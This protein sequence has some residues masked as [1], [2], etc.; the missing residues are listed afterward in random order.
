MHT[1]YIGQACLFSLN[2]N[3][4][5]PLFPDS[6]PLFYI[7]LQMSLFPLTTHLYFDIY[8]A[9][10]ISTY[11]SSLFTNTYNPHTQEYKYSPVLSSRALSLTSFV[12]IYLATTSYF[13]L[14]QSNCSTEVLKPH[15]VA[16][17]SS[18]TIASNTKSY[19][20]VWLSALLP[21]QT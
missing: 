16:Q 6:M 4:A 12:S 18:S 10:V 13:L 21:S 17:H 5:T 1:W 11:N 19:F 9:F 2:S 20:I 8:D 15:V 3:L 14:L 7:R